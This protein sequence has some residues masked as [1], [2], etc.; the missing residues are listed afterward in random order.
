MDVTYFHAGLTGK[1]HKRDYEGRK[2]SNIEKMSPLN[3][4]QKQKIMFEADDIPQGSW[5]R[6]DPLAVTIPARKMEKD[7][8]AKAS[9]EWAIEGTLIDTGSSADILFYRT[10]KN[11][12]YDDADLK[13]SAYNIHGF[14]KEIT[15]PKGEVTI[16]MPLGEI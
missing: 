2:I 5:G 7:K 8:D 11:M 3:E 1:I 15:N 9:E 6:T 4:W 14:N 10:F 12:G 13:P 16:K